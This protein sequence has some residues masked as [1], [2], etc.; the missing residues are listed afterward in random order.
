MKVIVVGAGIMG[1]S[2]AWSLA[3]RGADVTVLEQGPL[4][5]PV[6]SSVDDHRLI[7]HPYGARHGYAAMVVEAY[8]AWE[9]MWADLGERHYHE[10]GTLVLGGPDN[11]HAKLNAEGVERLGLTVEWLSP[12]QLAGEYPLLNAQGLT[13]GFRLP[14]GGT[15][16]CGRIVTALIRHLTLDG[17]E[18]RGGAEVTEV[19][20][21]AGTVML[22]GGERLS[23]DAVVVAAGAWVTRLI[24][25]MAARVVPSRQVVIYVRPPAGTGDLWRRMPCILDI[26]GDNNGFYLVPPTPGTGLKIGDHIFSRQ[27]DP[28]DPRIVDPAEAGA[29]LAKCAPRF[30]NIGQ[31]RV[32]DAKACFYTAEPDEKFI[33]E[34]NGR[35]VILS[36]C[37][38]HGFKF[39]AVVGQRTADLVLGQR[40]AAEVRRWAAGEAA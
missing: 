8:A 23:A 40:E 6:A 16:R 3:K 27:G 17:V 36:A 26:D 30:H 11:E 12:A 25:A 18:I 4:P 9:E 31:Y 19:D 10:S 1:L 39:G 37:S 13:G 24:P 2:T 20:P 5:N 21:V 34:Q 15:L 38:G 28:R 14:T 29:I 33:V 22:A 35:A 7:R 32:A